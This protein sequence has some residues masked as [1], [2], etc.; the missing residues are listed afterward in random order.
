MTTEAC[1]GPLPAFVRDAVHLAVTIGTTDPHQVVT[2]VHDVLAMADGAIAAGMP[3]SHLVF[4]TNDRQVAQLV[5]AEARY[6]VDKRMHTPRPT[7]M[8]ISP[9]G[10]DRTDYYEFRVDW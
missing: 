2:A 10:P 9:G 3:L 1:V 7:T 6:F 4:F 8:Y 5:A